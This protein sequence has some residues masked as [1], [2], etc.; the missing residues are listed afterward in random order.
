ME[1]N[2]TD[3]I[4]YRQLKEGEIIEKEDEVYVDSEKG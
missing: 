3:W 4:N 1:N 2:K